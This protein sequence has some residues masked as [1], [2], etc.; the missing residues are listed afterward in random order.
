LSIVKKRILVIDDSEDISRLIQIRLERENYHVV[1]AYDGIEGLKIIEALNPDLVILDLTLPGLS[2]QE[3]C[4][5]VREGKDMKIRHTP[6]IML[7][8]KRSDVDKVIGMV[9]GANHY[10][11]KPFEL[12]ELLKKIKEFL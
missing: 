9:I 6:I 5:A 1:L 12:D 2:W 10:M 4:K 3:V 11:T 7:T 8:G